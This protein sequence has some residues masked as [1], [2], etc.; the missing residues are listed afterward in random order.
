MTKHKTQH[1]AALTDPK[2]VA[3]LMKDISEYH[4]SLVVRQLMLIS[5]LLLCR[6]GEIRLLQ[7]D[8]VNFQK[9]C[10]VIKEERMK[11]REEH[12][13]PLSI[14]ALEILKV[15]MNNDIQSQYVFPSVKNSNKPLSG[16]SVNRAFRSMGYDSKKMT[17][18]GFRAMAKNHFRRI[19]KFPP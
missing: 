6:P 7:W 1:F 5:P 16:N 11:S 8:E 14:Q 18:H 17:A 4:G 10:I 15:M 12:W 19:I 2:D 13:V 3:Q 9:S